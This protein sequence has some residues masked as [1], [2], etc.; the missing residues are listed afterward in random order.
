MVESD[1]QD[2]AWR[3]GLADV[4]VSAPRGVMPHVLKFVPC[5]LLSFTPHPIVVT[6]WHRSLMMQSK[7]RATLH[8]E[9]NIPACSQ[10]VVAASQR[11]MHSMVERV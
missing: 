8:S 10:P 5:P 4:H 9:G 2:G 3:K 7:H 1:R 11:D 6:G